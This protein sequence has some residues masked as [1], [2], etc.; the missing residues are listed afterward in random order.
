MKKLLLS[1]AVI[2]ATTVITNAQ[3]KKVIKDEKTTK[4]TSSVPQKVHN[5]FSKHKRHNGTKTKHTRVVEK[6]VK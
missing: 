2:A 3:E 6:S 1:V 5:T 4:Q